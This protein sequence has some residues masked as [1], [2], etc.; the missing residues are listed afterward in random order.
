MKKNVIKIWEAVLLAIIVVVNSGCSL[1]RNYGTEYNFETDCQYSYYDSRDDWKRVQSDGTGQYILKNQ[2]IYY[3]N[4]ET[5]HLTPLCNKPNCLHDNEIDL[6]KLSD[7]NAYAPDT[8]SADERIQYYEGYIYYVD[9]NV[10]QTC[11]YRVKKDGSKKDKVF[12]TDDNIIISNWLIHRGCFYYS[13]AAFYYG[14]EQSTQIYKKCFLKSLELS[15]NMSE[16][17]AKV[18]YESDEEHTIHGLYNLKAY[19]N[20]LCYEI[21]SNQN[22]YKVTNAESWLR[23]V[24]SP[25]YLYNIET[26]ENC[27]VS[28]PK[29]C[30][31]TTIMK[32]VVFLKDKMLLILYDNLQDSEFP[33]P[34]YSVNYDLTDMEIWLNNLEQGK[35]VQSY[36]NYVILSD[37]PLHYSTFVSD[38]GIY[39]SVEKDPE[40]PCI[41]VEIYSPD[42]E[43][44]SWFIYPM[45][46]NE[47]N[48][49]GFGPDGVNVEFEENDDSW[50]VYELNFDDVL[51]CQGEEI[52]LNLVSTR[53]YGV[54]N[55]E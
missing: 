53:K 10:N 40:N 2:Y 7:C 43:R 3:Y 19:Q 4:T 55:R 22:D 46:Q 54:L 24:Y 14:E 21:V 16:K 13:F 35:N 15:S 48:F 30:S 38:D 25:M 18:I 50:S 29:Y 9:N 49:T 20:Y 51:N 32:D 28:I 33:L 42:A 39:S 36:D 34:I 31:E 45:N 44:L 1:K 26:G 27:E 41:N 23:Q 12:T 11:L 6:N 8:L 47:G 37:G 5:K 17:N 52:A